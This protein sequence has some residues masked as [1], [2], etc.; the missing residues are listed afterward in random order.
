MARKYTKLNATK[1]QVEEEPE[2][3]TYTKEFIQKRLEHYKG[4]VQ[5][6]EEILKRFD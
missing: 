4:V 3:Y 5:E 2:T 1:L 6:Y